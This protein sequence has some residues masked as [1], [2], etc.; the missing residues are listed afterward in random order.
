LLSSISLISHKNKYLILSIKM[1]LKSLLIPL[2][3]VA[4][5]LPFT[6]A[7]CE[8]DPDF[9]WS[10]VWQGT[11]YDYTCYFLS[12]NNPNERAK[13]R[14]NWC[15]KTAEPQGIPIKDKCRLSCDNCDSNPPRPPDNDP[16]CEDYPAN[17]KDSTGKACGWYN[18]QRCNK[19]GN[20]RRNQGETANTA[21]CNCGGG[22][23]E[24]SQWYD[25]RGKMYN[26]KWYAGGTGTNRCDAGGWKFTRKGKTANDVCCACRDDSV[27]SESYLRANT[28]ETVAEE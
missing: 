24:D 20:K 6:N 9:K 4:L 11:K 14:N 7:V 23:K 19:F 8:D 26:C 3:A 21:C 5:T 27:V 15:G 16:T 13:R 12:P 25:S 10:S 17:W 1:F 2:F 18:D 22:C 28:M